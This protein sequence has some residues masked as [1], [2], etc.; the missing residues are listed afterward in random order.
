MRTRRGRDALP[1]WQL[2]RGPGSLCRAIGV[3]R[4]HD[5]VDLCRGSL[6]LSDGAPLPGR[7]VR[8]TP[9]I[10][11]DYAGPDAQR[12]WRFLVAG[13]RAVSGRRVP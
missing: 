9:R 11:V 13:S 10:G 5:G 6:Y 2:C 4:G 1:D 7:R 12:P 3:H 8:R